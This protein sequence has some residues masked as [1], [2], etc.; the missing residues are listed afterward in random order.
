MACGKPVISTRVPSGVPWVNR[1]GETGITVP[2]GD[3]AALRAAIVML[4]EDRARRTRMGAAGRARV[5][6]E[7]SMPKM[8]AAV[9][10]LYRE[11]LDERASG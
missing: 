6:S 2:P 11:L 7:F 1:D 9:A 5:A 3:A 8:R 10:A 4:A